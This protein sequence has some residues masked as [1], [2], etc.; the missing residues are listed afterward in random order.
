MTRV[1]GL[2]VGALLLTAGCGVGHSA[3]AAQI[4]SSSAQGA[5]ASASEHAAITAVARE[6]PDLFKRFPS[7]PGE[8]SC[9]VNIGGPN[10][11]EMLAVTC[12]MQVAQKGPGWVVTLTQDYAFNGSHQFTATYHVTATGTVSQ[13]VLSGNP[14]PTIP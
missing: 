12:E 6:N 14:L 13:P 5:P 4:G 1:A 2:V 11:G 8:A 9:P 7:E 10:P 3:P